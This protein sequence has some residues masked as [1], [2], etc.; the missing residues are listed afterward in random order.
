MV[1][2]TALGFVS[3]KFDD[4]TF[5]MSSYCLFIYFF[6]RFLMITHIYTTLHNDPQTDRSPDD[7]CGRDKK[8]TKAHCTVIASVQN[9]LHV[10]Y[11]YDFSKIFIRFLAMGKGNKKGFI[12]TLR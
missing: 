8:W 10:T 11:E 7:C 6:L 4:T 2:A 1:A 12:S 5:L 3:F 9:T